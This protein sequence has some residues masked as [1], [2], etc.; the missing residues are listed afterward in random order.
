L[1]KFRLG[2]EESL[3]ALK[4]RR[5]QLGTLVTE[6]PA[7][8][9]LCKRLAL[10]CFLLGEIYHAKKAESEAVP[11]WQQAHQLYSKRVASRPDDLLASLSLGVCCSRLMGSQAADPC[12]LQAVSLLEQ[13][14]KRLVEFLGRYPETPWIW[15]TLREN[16]RCLIL[17][18]WNAGQ[19]RRGEHTFKEYERILDACAREHPDNPRHDLYSLESLVDVSCALGE[20]KQLAAALPI[21]R[22][23]AALADRYTSI[24]SMYLKDRD[25]SPTCLLSLAVLLRRLGDPAES[26]RQAEHARLLFEGFS[27]AA[28]EMNEHGV[29]LST[30]WVYI[31]K[32][33]WEL[34]QADAALA[35]FREAAAVQRQV[36]SRAPTI[37]QNRIIL[38]RCYDHLIY[39][40]GL[41]GNRAEVVTA[42]REQEKLWPENP[43]RLREMSRDYAEL[44]AAVGKGD[45]QLSQ[46]EQAERQRYLNESSRLEGLSRRETRN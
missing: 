26:L 17:C 37:L 19:T 15:W 42:L 2:S 24:P 25:Y 3:S 22:E 28:P 6:N 11:C 30:A 5:A 13:T 41:R 35:A 40:E 14:G 8:T 12:Y 16:Y 39:R 29:G 36:F 32:A 33:R 27:R 43:A 1:I 21:A 44:A 7:K 46:E 9:V 4:E 34:G 18:H 20:A 45:K 10:T 23:A 31:G 38:S